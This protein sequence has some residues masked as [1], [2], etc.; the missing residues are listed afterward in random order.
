MDRERPTDTTEGE[1]RQRGGDVHR[2]RH[3][4]PE[5]R[6]AI[7]RSGGGG[8]GGWLGKCSLPCILMASLIWDNMTPIIRSFVHSFSSCFPWSIIQGP[9]H[10]RTYLPIRLCGDVG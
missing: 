1:E 9:V 4:R 7:R 10:R 2:R 6:D 3:R 8:G 5:K